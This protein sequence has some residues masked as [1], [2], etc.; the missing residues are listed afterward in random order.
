VTARE[1]LERGNQATN[2]IDAF[3]NFWRGFNNL[4]FPVGNGLERDKIKLFLSQRISEAQAEEMLQANAS[5]VAYLLSQPVIDMRGNGRD[6]AQNIQA[7]NAATGSLTKLQELFIVIYQ[8]R[9]NLEHGQKSPNRD[10]DIQLC[11]FAS[12][13]VAHVVDRNA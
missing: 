3:S 12:P 8:V 11:H 4:Y 6:T 1:W 10:R 5:G 2:P 9:C 13:L 7:F